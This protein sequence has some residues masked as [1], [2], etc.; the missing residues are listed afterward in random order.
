V[1]LY[2]HVVEVLDKAAVSFMIQI[3]QECTGASTS[4]GTGTATA[5]A[6]VTTPTSATSACLAA[7]SS[8]A[9]AEAWAAWST[10]T[11]PHQIV[12]SGDGSGNSTVCNGGTG[13]VVPVMPTT[14]PPPAA[15]ADSSTASFQP[16][17]NGNHDAQSTAGGDASDATPQRMASEPC[18]TAAAGAADGAPSQFLAITEGVSEGQHRTRRRIVA[19]SHG[20]SSDDGLGD[21][22]NAG[23]VRYVAASPLLLALRRP[24]TSPLLL[25]LCRPAT[26]PLLLTLCRP[27]TSRYFSPCIDLSSLIFFQRDADLC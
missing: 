25:T 7:H 11:G 21:S 9:M 17:S 15:P 3:E 26:S 19:R 18:G 16:S 23:C 2:F 14:I 22:T 5:T 27:A 13:G 20:S 24:A 8:E 12:G 6:P 4:A 1:T 10:Y